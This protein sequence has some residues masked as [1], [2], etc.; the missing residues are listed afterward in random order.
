[1]EPSF[2]EVLI[3]GVFEE[4]NHNLYVRKDM[5]RL[6][7]WDF[8]DQNETNVERL[9]KSIV[10]G[11]L[12]LWWVLWVYL[13]LLV[14]IKHK[15]DICKCIDVDD[16]SW[17]REGRVYSAVLSKPW[18]LQ[19]W[20]LSCFSDSAWLIHISLYIF[21][22]LKKKKNQLSQILKNWRQACYLEFSLISL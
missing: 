8:A 20:I 1:M 19:P 15:Y 14:G 18:P 21:N 9:F 4:K 3:S 12:W 7:T 2:F 13:M 11:A 17:R 10:G 6:K 22:S 5:R 16:S